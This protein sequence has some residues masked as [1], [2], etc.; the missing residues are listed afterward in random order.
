MQQMDAGLADFVRRYPRLLVLTGAGCS[1]ESGIPDYRDLEGR[2]KR[3]APMSY[4]AFTREDAA[5]RRYW[6][7]S[8]VGW[9][10]IAASHPGPAH[11]A[12]AQLEALGY[13][14]LLVTQ[15]VDGLHTAAGSRKVL[16]LHGRLDTVRCLA[17]GADM[18]RADFQ[19]KLQAANADW[20]QTHV[21]ADIETA[22]D[23]DAYLQQLDFSGFA[24]PACPACAGTLKPDVVFFG[25]NVPRTRVDRA[26]ALL[27]SAD[28]LLVVGSSLMVYSGYR[29]A[30]A[31]AEWGKPM[32]AVNLGS[33]RADAL[34]V[35]KLQQPLGAALTAL[36]QQLA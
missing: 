25:E 8:M 19:Q 32:A 3:P 28:A 20:L 21:P 9:P 7:R 30:R 18:A 12:L 35:L 6:A 16:D 22:P 11:V 17:C 34:F 23:G 1:T 33:T 2:W 5:R 14:H 13:V 36:A 24:V 15:N 27:R 26:M 4:Q 10:R 29:F 31:A